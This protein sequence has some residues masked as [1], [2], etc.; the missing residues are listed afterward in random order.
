MS[1][2]SA[3]PEQTQ[4]FLVK[5]NQ[6]ERSTISA[7]IRGKYYYVCQLLYINR[8]QDP[9]SYGGLGAIL[10]IKRSNVKRNL[11]LFQKQTNRNIRWWLAA[12]RLFSEENEDLRPVQRTYRPDNLRGLCKLYIGPWNP[13]AMHCNK[14]SRFHGF[15]PWQLLCS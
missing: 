11:T 2:A 13:K 1:L 5:L 3:T 7:Y 6:D 9:A 15:D 8:K 4:K 12:P 10:K 14:I